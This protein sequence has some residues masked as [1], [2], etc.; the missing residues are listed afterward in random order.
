ML[1]LN[2]LETKPLEMSAGQAFSVVKEVPNRITPGNRVIQYSQYIA[3]A[4]AAAAA[5]PQR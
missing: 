1:S 5:V 2:P 4:A 3:R